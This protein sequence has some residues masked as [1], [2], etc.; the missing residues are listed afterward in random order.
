M[1]KLSTGIGQNDKVSE[2][3]SLVGLSQGASI[4]NMGS[5]VLDPTVWDDGADRESVGS[6]LIQG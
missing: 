3:T 4:E 1:E 2:V 6:G 5:G